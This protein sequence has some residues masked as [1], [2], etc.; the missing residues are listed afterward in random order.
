[1][2][3]NWISKL[4]F[5]GLVFLPAMA[6]LICPITAW[7]D[8]FAGLQADVAIDE[9]LDSMRGGFTSADGLE[10]SFGVEQAVFID[11]I[12]Q[13]ATNFTTLPLTT[14]LQQQ[15]DTRSTNLILTQRVNIL[16]NDFSAVTVVADGLRP[17]LDTLIQNSGDQRVIDT[18]TMIN[19]TVSS[20]GLLHALNLSNTLQQQQITTRR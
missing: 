4:S 20:L 15:I 10:I 16:Q 2:S 11:G 7:G 3:A 5:K 19:A 18:F 13:I 1:M 8:P 12:L 14:I 9:E 6:A 17:Q